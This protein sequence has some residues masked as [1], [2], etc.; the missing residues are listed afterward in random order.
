MADALSTAMFV[1]GESRAL[2]Y[3]R[4]YGG[5]EMIMINKSNQIICTK[6]LI[7]T[8]KQNDAAPDYKVRYSE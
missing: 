1:L 6:G 4:Q 3:W 5:F 8:F 2:N 7:D